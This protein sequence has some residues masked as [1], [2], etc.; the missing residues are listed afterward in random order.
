MTTEMADGMV[1]RRFDSVEEAVKTVLGESGGSN[2]DRLRRKFREQGWY[3]RGLDA[4][5]QAEIARRQEGVN[6]D[7]LPRQ[8]R[9]K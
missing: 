9:G 5:V 8:N 4:Y 1:T 2:V 7:M 3:E 6:P